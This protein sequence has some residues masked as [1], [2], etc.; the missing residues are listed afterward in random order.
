MCFFIDVE[1]D[2]GTATRPDDLKSYTP[3]I[4][5]TIRVRIRDVHVPLHQRYVSNSCNNPNS[6]SLCALQQNVYFTCDSNRIV[7]VLCIIGF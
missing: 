5:W 1:A 2:N 4:T 6:F 3:P 7:I